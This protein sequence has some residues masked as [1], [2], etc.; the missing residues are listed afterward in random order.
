MEGWRRHLW[1]LDLAQKIK[2]F[3][4]LAIEN[5]I[6]TWD[7]VQRKGWE[8]PHIFHLCSKEE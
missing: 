8:G 4:W 1:Q 6:L 3:T 2:F 5:K 7:T